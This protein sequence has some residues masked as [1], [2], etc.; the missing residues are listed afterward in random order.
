MEEDGGIIGV[1]GGRKV[2]EEDD[3]YGTRICSVEEIIRNFEDGCFSTVACL[4]SRLKSFKEL[5]RV[6]ML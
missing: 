3:G 4:E 2:E 6:E 5:P 1:K